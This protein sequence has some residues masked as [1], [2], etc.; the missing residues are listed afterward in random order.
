ME[1]AF[2]TAEALCPD[3]VMV[4]DKGLPVQEPVLDGIA[5]MVCR[6]TGLRLGYTTPIQRDILTAIDRTTY[7][8]IAEPVIECR[9]PDCAVNGGWYVSKIGVLCDEHLTWKPT[10]READATE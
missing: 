5:H 6:L 1:A 8:L 10:E 9:A 2:E 4:D 3:M 7:H